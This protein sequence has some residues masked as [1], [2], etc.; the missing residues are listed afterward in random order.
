M[1]FDHIG[2]TRGHTL[3]TPPVSINIRKS[4]CHVARETQN[5]IHQGHEVGGE[6]PVKSIFIYSAASLVAFSAAI[7]SAEIDADGSGDHPLV[8]RVLGSYI[9]D[10]K[11]TDFDRI[12]IPTGPNE[13]EGC[14]GSPQWASSETLEGEHW[15]LTY[16]F[17]NPEISTLR[18]KRSYRDTLEAAGFETVFAGSED[19]L[20]YCFLREGNLFL[21]RQIYEDF[22]PQPRYLVARSP[23]G[24]T[25]V[26][27]LTFVAGHGIGTVAFVDVVTVEDMKLEMELL[28]LTASEIEEGLIRDGRVA[29]SNILFGFNSAE[30]LPESADPLETIATLMKDRPGISLLVVGHTDSVGGFDYNLKLSHDRATSVVAWL[31]DRHGIDGARLRSAGAGMMSPVSSNRTEEGRTLNR[32]V[33][34]VELPN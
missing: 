32:R 24:G 22:H 8:P 25:L 12:T 28:P 15:R 34:L 18:V 29:I 4:Y 27:M 7:A 1:I 16:Q 21:V 20:G 23:D 5:S 14:G 31:R 19:E 33:E 2:P 26:S 17:N 10:Y 11:Y 9:S 30:I 3:Q 13:T 6:M